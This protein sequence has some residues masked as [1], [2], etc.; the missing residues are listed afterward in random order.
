MTGLGSFHD[1]TN[2]RVL[3]LLVDNCD[4]N[5]DVHEGTWQVSLVLDVMG[6]LMLQ[7]DSGGERDCRAAC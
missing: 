5:V 7:A 1:S 3:D 2:K 4:C 6:L